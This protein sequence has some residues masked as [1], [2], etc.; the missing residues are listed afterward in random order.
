MENYT[1]NGNAASPER[2]M[3]K[4]YAKN[5]YKKNP[6]NK[7]YSI[8]RVMIK[9]FHAVSETVRNVGLLNSYYVVDCS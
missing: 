1:T 3:G 6:I 9:K 8:Y 4:D 5:G 7:Q 2:K